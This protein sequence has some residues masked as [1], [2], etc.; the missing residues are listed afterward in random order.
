MSVP[1]TPYL[2]TQTLTVLV[3]VYNEEESLT[4]FVVE[5][6]QFLAQTPL[7]TTVLFVNDGSTDGSLALLRSICGQDTRYELI[8][9][10]RNQGLST[11]IKAGIDHCRSTLVGYID[12][13]I[14]TTPLD[15]LRFLEFFPAYDMV[16]GIRAK[17][18]DTLVK[19]LSSKLANTVRRTLIND[20]IQDTGCPLKI[21]KIEYAR[22]LP[23]FHG[24]HRFLGALVQLQ[25]G[26]VKQ[27]PV[28]HFPRFAG[29]A[30]Y[31]LWNRAW[32]PLVDTFGFRWIRSRWKN[33]EI[34]EV[35]RA[36][37]RPADG[38]GR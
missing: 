12:S 10:S 21:I 18:Q 30:K 37:S 36:E 2:A 38:G 25:G 8:S 34:G 6:N 3:P 17:R 7:P 27:L 9:L 31:T 13:D 19:K 22:R 16:N 28:Q 5:M 15:F 23:L 1:S 20:G 26:Q 35:L 11:A 33:Y 24:M 32:K 29:T 4:Q 14:Q